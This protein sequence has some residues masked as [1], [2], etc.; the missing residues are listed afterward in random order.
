[1]DMEK[2]VSRYAEMPLGKEKSRFQCDYQNCKRVLMSDK[3]RPFKCGS[4]GHGTMLLKKPKA[5]CC[6]CGEPIYAN[7][8]SKREVVCFK[9][10]A[11][12]VEEVRKLEKEFGHKIRAKR[13]KPR[14][15]NKLKKKDGEKDE[16]L[17]IIR[18]AKDYRYALELRDEKKKQ[19]EDKNSSEALV[20][21]RKKGGFSQKSIAEY[22]GCSVQYLSKMENGC[23]P[24]NT[25]AIEF[26]KEGFK[27]PKE[28]KESKKK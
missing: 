3:S 12:M 17:G 28:T 21:A 11:W 26:L 6:E 22:L 18:N 16:P 10:T 5:Y 15:G 27:F 9:C 25:K 13:N 14:K 7:V 8:E 24:L 20:E 1:M 23:K 4:C 19:K 2:L